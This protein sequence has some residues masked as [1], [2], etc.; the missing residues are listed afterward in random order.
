MSDISSQARSAIMAN[1]QEQAD[2][3]ERLKIAR[4]ALKETG[5]D[6]SE[7]DKWIKLLDGLIKGAGIKPK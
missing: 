4:D 2:K 5:E 1:L 7:M 3:L 6:T